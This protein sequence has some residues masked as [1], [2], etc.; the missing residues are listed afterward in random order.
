MKIR[1]RNFTPQDASRIAKLCNNI[2]I[3]NNVKDYFPHPYEENDALNFIDSCLLQ[4]PTTT[5]AID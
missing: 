2:N 1:L 3:W 5:F 4:N